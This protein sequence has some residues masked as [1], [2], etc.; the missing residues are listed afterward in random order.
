MAPE[1]HWSLMMECADTDWKPLKDK[2]ALAGHCMATLHDCGFIDM[3]DVVCAT[4]R[5][6]T[7]GYP[8]PTIQRDTQVR[9]WSA[10]LHQN[11]IYS[12][13]RFGHW[14]YE[15]SNMDHSFM[16]GVEVVDRILSGKEE[17]IAKF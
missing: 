13:G 5:A 9:N 1:G 4:H 16:Q 15:V 14:K 6:H 17:T 10:Y 11:Q 3:N 12:R 8:V 7:F 2:Q